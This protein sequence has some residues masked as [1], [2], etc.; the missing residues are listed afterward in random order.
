MAF[1]GNPFNP[2]PFLPPEVFLG[3]D[4]E[5]SV[6][7]GLLSRLGH[8]KPLANT[9]VLYGPRG[10]GKTSL[11]RVV[12]QRR[13][14]F[15]ED[16]SLARRVN[17]VIC[18]PVM[19]NELGLDAIIND[20]PSPDEVTHRGKLQA[21]VK[22]LFSGE[23]ERTSTFKTNRSIHD[24][25]TSI[26]SDSPVLLCI[27]EAHIADVAT[28]DSIV[29]GTQIAAGKGIP[30]GL[31][32]AGTPHLPEFLDSLKAS[33]VGRNKTIRLERLDDRFAELALRKPLENSGFE[34]SDETLF[35][36]V[37]SETQNYPYFV[38]LYGEIFWDLLSESESK[39]IDGSIVPV[40]REKFIIERDNM[41]R[42]RY[43]ELQKENLIDAA[44][45]VAE[46]Y[47]PSNEN[48]HREDLVDQ[49]HAD[50]KLE[51]SW[52]VIESLYEI[53][54]IWPSQEID[55]YEPGIPS[56]MSY[57]L[58]THKKSGELR[59]RDS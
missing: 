39:Q 57:V 37:L 23:G 54:Y 32:L 18:N 22:P 35:E 27:D 2:G 1:K 6:F 8:G 40:A 46:M 15:C 34:I 31:V 47:R 55:L 41:Y 11:L 10:N 49:V 29:L 45:V 58:E 38:Q 51:N 26:S 19:I 50:L 42:G 33:F 14:T 20:E 9:V 53:G 7:Q 12:E 36:E 30:V 4:A 24:S 3:R 21:G 48:V 43:R 25:L 16:S 5:L 59:R 52:E 28:M 17:V 13:E 44:V 56:L